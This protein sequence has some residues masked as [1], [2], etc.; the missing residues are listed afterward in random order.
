M[1][2]NTYGSA[3]QCKGVGIDST[4]L[5][6]IFDMGTLVWK[7]S[8][9]LAIIYLQ[10]SIECYNKHGCTMKNIYL[11][12]KFLHFFVQDLLIRGVM[13]NTEQCPLYGDRIDPYEPCQTLPGLS[14]PSP[15]L[16]GKSALQHSSASP[17]KTGIYLVA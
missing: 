6:C 10:K 14:R 3:L 7:V 11:L 2:K 1:K 4:C 8:Q 16:T 12:W 5:R 9:I 15:G 17:W 13:I